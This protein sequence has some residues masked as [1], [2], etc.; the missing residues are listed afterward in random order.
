[1]QVGGQ[2]LDGGI[3]VLDARGDAFKLLHAE[4]V[5]MP[6]WRAFRSS[7]ETV[8]SGDLLLVA[9]YVDSDWRSVHEALGDVPVVVVATRPQPGDAARALAAGAFGYLDLQM[10]ATALH[11][12]LMGA[13][14]GEP[15]YSRSALGEFIRMRA[16]R[17]FAH[18]GMGALTPR[19]REVLALIALG[20]ADKEI[21]LKLCIATGTAQKHVTNLLRKLGVPNRAAAVAAS[22]FV[23]ALAP[24]EVAVPDAESSF[25]YSSRLRSS[26]GWSAPRAAS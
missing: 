2:T 20:A 6:M 1:M 11:R 14:R 12:A 26:D 22:Y 21:A 23:P 8:R 17:T 16:P 19:Q 24:A 13:L 5:Y 15:A 18:E 25:A 3:A 7:A 9:V 4:I 10:P